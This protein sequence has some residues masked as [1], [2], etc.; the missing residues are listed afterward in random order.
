MDTSE[1]MSSADGGNSVPGGRNSIA[2]YLP[3]LCKVT[4]EAMKAEWVRGRVGENV[5][6][7]TGWQGSCPSSVTNSTGIHSSAAAKGQGLCGH[8]TRQ[9]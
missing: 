4:Q 6:S 8:R 3:G 7:E 5:V 1:V 2:K 9:L